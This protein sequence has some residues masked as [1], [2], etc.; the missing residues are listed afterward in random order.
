VEDSA[1]VPGL[2]GG[3]PGLLLEHHEARLRSAR[4]QLPGGSQPE[5]ASADDGYV[6][7]LVS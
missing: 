7:M 4:Q 1:V 3:D 5:D 2:V 6:D